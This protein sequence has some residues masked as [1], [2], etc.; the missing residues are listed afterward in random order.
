MVIHAFGGYYGLAI[1]WVL[2]RP[3]LHQSKRLNGSVYHSDLFAM[4]GEW[5]EIVTPL[6]HSSFGIPNILD[7]LLSN[8]LA[9]V[10]P[11][12]LWFGLIPSPH[13]CTVPVD[14]LAQFQLG[15]HRPRRRTAQSSHQHLHCPCFLCSHHCGHLQHV[16]EERKTGHGN[17]LSLKN[18]SKPEKHTAVEPALQC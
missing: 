15:H 13:R 7:F 12:K 4:I 3:N 6:G 14:V 1:S 8:L 2:Y 9:C 18:T 11:L 16:S 17:V 10:N 5:P